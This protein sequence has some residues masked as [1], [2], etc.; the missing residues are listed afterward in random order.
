MGKK[1]ELE[2]TLGKVK[3]EGLQAPVKLKILVTIIDRKKVDFYVSN[4]E[5]FGAN[6]QEIIYASGTTPRKDIFGIK[7]SEKAVL[8]SMVRED[9]IKEILATYEDK[10]F[11]TK[12]GKGIAFTIPV[13]SMIGVMLYQ[14][15]AGIE[16]E[17]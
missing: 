11:Q 14:F 5:G 16:K 15:L 8:L 10:Y 13:K 3:T 6:V 7:V 12:N 1:K 2:N 17:K 9:R 4:L